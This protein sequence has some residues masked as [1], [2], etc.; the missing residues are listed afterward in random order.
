ME[1]DADLIVA[2]SAFGM[3]IDKP[4]IR[5]VVHAQI[6]ES[7]D[8]YYQ[9]VGRA[10]RDGEPAD[11]VLVYRSEDLA[12]G[13]FFSA[14][15][16][17]RADVAAVVAARAEAGGEPAAIAESTGFGRRKAG[18]LLNLVELAE[19]TGA[20]GDP[21]DA[22][23]ELAEARRSLERSRVDM[24]RGYAET[25]R[26]R[27]DF[28]VGY[29]GEQLPARCG[30]CDNCRAGTAPDPAAERDAPFPVQSRVRHEEF[31]TG[32]VTDVEDDRLT[33]LFDDVGYRTLSADLVVEH[34]LLEV[35]EG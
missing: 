5:F 30:V 27:A 35:E 11:G 25:D 2:T 17:K 1:G 8:T 31:G 24:M 12:L 9:E 15:V 21:V 33:V 6:P 7:P 13:R 18:R 34:D 16:P 29:F 28:L 3:G 19:Q 26:C 32:T 10:G 22:V 4:D 14:G 23:R 20:G